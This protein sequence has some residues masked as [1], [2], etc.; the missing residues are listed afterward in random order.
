MKIQG[1]SVSMAAIDPAGTMKNVPNTGFLVPKIIPSQIVS[2]QSP[3]V[4][5]KDVTNLE[6]LGKNSSKLVIRQALPLLPTIISKDITRLFKTSV[7]NTIFV[8]PLQLEKFQ[9]R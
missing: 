6:H 9:N 5:L 1:L 8:Y 7:D 2:D 4:Y 3:F